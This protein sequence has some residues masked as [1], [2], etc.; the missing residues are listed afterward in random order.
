MIFT[1]PPINFNDYLS[2]TKPYILL[3]LKSLLKFVTENY[4]SIYCV[5]GTS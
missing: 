5:Q 3:A 1:V 2:V 4:M